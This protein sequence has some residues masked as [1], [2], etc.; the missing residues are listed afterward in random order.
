MLSNPCSTWLLLS[1]GWVASDWISINSGTTQSV[2]YLATYLRTVDSCFA[3]TMSTK[4][5]SPLSRFEKIEKTLD[6]SS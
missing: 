6:E 5:D 3:N 1:G 2:Y 4:G